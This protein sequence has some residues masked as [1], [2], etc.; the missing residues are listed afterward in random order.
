MKRK[1]KETLTEFIEREAEAA[2]AA[3]NAAMTPAEHLD[4]LL[5]NYSKL[6]R[7]WLMVLNSDRP[8][9][10]VLEQISSEMKL[11]EQRL[12]PLLRCL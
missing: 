1:K 4:C 9:W 10:L 5:R 8:S 11:M 6:Q 3:E 12:E 7:L 2:L